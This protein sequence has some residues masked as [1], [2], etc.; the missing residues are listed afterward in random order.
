MGPVNLSGQYAR[1]ERESTPQAV[2]MP[3][4]FVQFMRERGSPLAEQEEKFSTWNVG[5]SAQLPGGVLPPF[6]EKVLRPESFNAKYG[7]SQFEATNPFG[8]RFTGS[9]RTRAIGGQGRVLEGL[10]GENAPSVGFQYEEP[11]RQESIISGNVTIPFQEGGI[12]S[13]PNNPVLAGQQHMLAYI[14]PEE[15]STLREQGG[16]VTPTGGQ[17]RG[18][19][20]IAS[21]PFGIGGLGHGVSTAAFGG[22]PS[23]GNVS[24]DPYSMMTPQKTPQLDMPAKNTQALAET[25]ANKNAEV[26]QKALDKHKVNEKLNA[27]TQTREGTLA[28]SE[29]RDV[30]NAAK[31]AAVADGYSHGAIGKA[32]QVANMNVAD[33]M[34][35]QT[36]ALIDP[37]GTRLT[38]MDIAN[39]SD[40][41]FSALSANPATQVEGDPESLL[42]QAVMGLGT[43]APGMMNP[44]LALPTTAIDLLS[45]ET[46]LLNLLG[47]PEIVG[48]VSEAIGLGRTPLGDLFSPGNV[49]EAA[50]PATDAGAV[51]TGRPSNLGPGIS[52]PP[53]AGIPSVEIGLPVPPT[54]T[55][56]LTGP[57]PHY[58]AEQL[59]TQ[60][61]VTVAQAREYLDSLPT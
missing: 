33:F 31:A 57:L 56:V 23:M 9:D 50:P 49:V 28:H 4:E 17:Y 8:Q 7:R 13:L 19:G 14:T 41:A 32:N 51:Y 24:V 5:I 16:G 48:D 2:G 26:S 30:F 6:M 12:A 42:G 18:P 44:A 29:A 55:E 36:L 52:L 45:G 15:A 38:A 47:V 61:G 25:V 34:G 27:V 59:A 10:F 40:A 3:E 58:T 46:G 37:S 11:N 54:A 43:T 20:G 53:P 21:F 35:N 22:H 1:Q 39:M 60:T